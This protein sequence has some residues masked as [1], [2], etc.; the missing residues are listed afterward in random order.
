VGQ[1]NLFPR[2]I[3]KVYRLGI[4]GIAL[5][6]FPVVIK[7]VPIAGIHGAGRH[8]AQKESKEESSAGWFHKHVF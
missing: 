3:I 4:F 7:M 1:I 8:Y 2:R 5:G 6:E